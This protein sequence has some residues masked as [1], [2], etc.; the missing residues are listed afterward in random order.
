MFGSLSRGAQAAPAQTAANEG[1]CTSLV[2]RPTWV[3][4]EHCSAFVAQCGD[5]STAQIERQFSLQ[6]FS[7]TF[8]PQ[9]STSDTFLRD[10][11]A[12]RNPG[13]S[14]VHIPIS[15][16]S[17][18]SARQFADQVIYFG[19]NYRGPPYQILGP[20]S[21]SA[22]GYPFYQSGGSVPNRIRA[23]GLDYFAP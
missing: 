16:P 3:V 8:D 23:P 4:A 7:S 18:V 6:G 17:G 20:N 1:V 12:F 14:N 19:D 11:E 13:G 21:N 2:C 15:A 10:L 22:A 5:P 9:G